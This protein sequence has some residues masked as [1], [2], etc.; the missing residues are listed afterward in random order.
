LELQGVH[1]EFMEKQKSLM[2]I[3]ENSDKVQRLK[4]KVK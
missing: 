2:E 4:T 3:D 1:G